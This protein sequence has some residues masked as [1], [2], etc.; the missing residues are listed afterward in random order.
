VLTIRDVEWR[1]S[2]Q[3]DS[4]TVR[5][6]SASIDRRVP[7]PAQGS[8][9]EL[10][11]LSRT[12][13]A[14]RTNAHH[15]GVCPVAVAFGVLQHSPDHL[16]RWIRDSRRTDVNDHAPNLQGDSRNLP[17]RNG[18]CQPRLHP[19]SS[20]TSALSSARRC[21]HKHHRRR[22]PRPQCHWRNTAGGGFVTETAYF[23]RK[24][25]AVT[26]WSPRQGAMAA[27]RAT[28]RGCSRCCPDPGSSV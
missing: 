13:G 1:S 28:A 26:G 17:L 23:P 5:V 27:N 16:E 3:V 12:G 19:P 4:T 8:G 20:C 22:Q 9:R 14:C 6:D 24:W 15:L 11:S 7:T 2:H 21:N 18:Q 25:A 10:D